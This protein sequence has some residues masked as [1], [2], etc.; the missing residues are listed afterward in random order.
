MAVVVGLGSGAAAQQV[1]YVDVAAPGAETGMSWDDAFTDLQDALAIAQPGD[2]IR[3]AEGTYWPDRGTGDRAA[4]FSLLNG[5][6]ILGGYAGYGAPDPDARDVDLYVTVLS[7]EI[8]DPL[9]ATDNSYHVVTGS[10]ADADAVLD[11][12][13][14]THGQADVGYPD[15]RGGGMIIMFTSPTVTRCRFEGNRAQEG[16]ALFIC[17][18]AAPVFSD[19]VFRRNAVTA[20]G[21]ALFD[22]GGSPELI[23][24]TFADNHADV[25][26]GAIAAFGSGASL[27]DCTFEGNSTEISGGGVYDNGGNLVLDGCTFRGNVQVS[28][29]TSGSPGGGGMFSKQSNPTLIGCT[30]INNLTSD[31]GGAFHNKDG[32]AELANCSI[33]NNLSGGSGGGLCDLGEGLTASSCRI[34]A[35]TAF[36]YGAG[37]YCADAG[38]ELVNCTISGN[39]TYRW[40]GGVCDVS[41]GSRLAGCVLWDNRDPNGTNED[42]QI[43]VLGDGALVDYCCIQGLT[44]D[45]GG[46]GNVGDDPS[47]ADP[48]GPDGIA[49]TLD[50]DM[51]LTLD[52]P[53]I[54]GGNPDFTP[55]PGATDLGYSPRLICGAVD[56]GAYEFPRRF[57]DYDCNWQLDLDDYAEWGNCMECLDSRS[58][59]DECEVFDANEDGRIDLVDFSRFQVERGRAG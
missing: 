25:S 22:M 7:G 51:R 50:D 32:H 38:T 39:T 19:C 28:G 54:D 6:V 23:R 9:D 43:L 21:G 30:F 29:G 12:F 15:N 57:A 45:L 20:N 36:G 35:N 58:L 11:G 41:A 14:I 46:M 4:T 42:A 52:S 10:D 26:G 59:P 33:L 27:I 17:F 47:F 2:D 34:L 24:C 3:V 40:G 31:A 44:G 56:M 55:E 13:T 5:V 37:V 1:R 16:G 49:G 18:G 53:C 48:Y 8:G